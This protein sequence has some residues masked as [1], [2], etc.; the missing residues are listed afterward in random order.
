MIAKF[1]PGQTCFYCKV[2]TQKQKKRY[3]DDGGDPKHE[4]QPHVCLGKTKIKEL[5][6]EGA[7]ILGLDKPE[8]FHPHSLRAMFITDLANNPGVSKKEIL[9]SARHASIS[10]SLAYQTRDGVSESAKFAALGMELPA[11]KQRGCQERVEQ[12][13]L[14]F[15]FCERSAILSS[16]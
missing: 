1:T 2:M 7:K 13:S 4:F 11:N 12:G 14:S 8:D 16:T 10:S 5:F 9:R 3:V 6:E 15:F